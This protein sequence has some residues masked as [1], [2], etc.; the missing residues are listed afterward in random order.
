MALMAKTP[1]KPNADRHKVKA[2]VLRLTPKI[3]EQLDKLAEANQ[4]R[5]TE[6]VRIAIRKHLTEAGLWPPT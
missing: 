1:K 3:R 2:M 5:V 6:E 4:S